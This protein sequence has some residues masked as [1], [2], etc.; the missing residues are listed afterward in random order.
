[1]ILPLQQYSK[2]ISFQLFK[3]KLKRD[4]FSEF[5][6]VLNRQSLFQNYNFVPEFSVLLKTA[7]DQKDSQTDSFGERNFQLQK[8]FLKNSM[9]ASKNQ[10]RTTDKRT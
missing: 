8:I 5:V 10:I 9:N 2:V 3:K 7:G 4:R 1:M 6:S